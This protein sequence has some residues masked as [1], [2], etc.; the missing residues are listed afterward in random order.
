MIAK[1]R[2]PPEWDMHDA[3][4]ITWLQNEKTQYDGSILDAQ[5]KSLQF[6]KKKKKG[7]KVNLLVNDV[8]AEFNVQILAQYL[9]IDLYNVKFYFQKTND[10]WIRD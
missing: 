1:F 4:W 10:A 8:R 5:R 6:I 7:E 2:L 3:T 9:S